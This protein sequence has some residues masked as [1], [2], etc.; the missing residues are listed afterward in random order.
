MDIN[1]GN[2]LLFLC[3]NQGSFMRFTDKAQGGF[4]NMRFE[5]TAI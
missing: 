1:Q 5:T 4:L 2:Y 3:I